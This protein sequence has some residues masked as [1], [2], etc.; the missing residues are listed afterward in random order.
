[1][2]RMSDKTKVTTMNQYVGL[3]AHS[4]IESGINKNLLFGIRRMMIRDVV[5]VSVD[6]HTCYGRM[7]HTMVSWCYQRW[8]VLLLCINKI[9]KAL[10]DT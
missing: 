7:Q 10:Q 5:T 6:A 9:L 4:A 3:K 8:W 1:M 2:T